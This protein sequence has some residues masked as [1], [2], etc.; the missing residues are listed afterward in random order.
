MDFILYFLAELYNLTDFFYGREEPVKS[1]LNEIEDG[2]IKG[3]NDPEKQ[4][5]EYRFKCAQW[6][7]TLFSNLAL[8]EHILGHMDEPAR[9]KLP[10][11]ENSQCSR[12]LQ[13]FPNNFALQ[14]HSET[15]H[16]D[17]G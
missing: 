9:D 5:E 13:L 2:E 7:K 16:S 11:A 3:D 12:C 17:E 1:D 14:Q 8:M 10:L 4:V 15:E 6:Q